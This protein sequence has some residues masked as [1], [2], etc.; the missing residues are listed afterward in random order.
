[1]ERSVT[2]ELLAPAPVEATIAGRVVAL[3]YPMRAVIAYQRE[4]ARIER[5][6][7]RPEDPDPRCICGVRKSSHSGASLIRLGDQDALLCIGFRAEDALLGESLFLFE[8]W[9]KIDLNIDPERW[10][11]CLWCG[12]HVKQPDGK[13]WL[14]PFT[15]EELEEKI[16][17]CSYTRAI[18]EK[19]F[20]ALT[21]WFPKAKPAT[22]KNVAPPGEPAEEN[23]PTLLTS[24]D[25]GL[26]P[27]SVT[28][29][30]L[31]NS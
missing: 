9:R 6:R 14:S 20:T 27:D 23:R 4:T 10:L 11:A 17:L 22:E 24:N 19:M 28:D 5:S 7:P 16:G 15:L 1:M 21:A 29:L 18:N 3:S 31:Q 2:E 13:T 25:S 30:S 26:T 12:M 8:S